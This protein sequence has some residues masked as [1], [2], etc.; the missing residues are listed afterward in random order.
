MIIFFTA[1]KKPQTQAPCSRISLSP[2]L[3]GQIVLGME[4]VRIIRN[5]K[6][7]GLIRSRL[8]GADAAT[9]PTL[10]F[11]D[12]HCECNVQWLEPLLARVH[13]DYRNVVSPII[14][15]IDHKNFQYLSTTSNLRGAFTWGLQFT[16]ETEPAD[17]RS[18]PIAPIIRSSSRSLVARPP[19]SRPAWLFVRSMR[20]T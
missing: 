6:R 12:S 14:D 9:S 10:T 17:S 2:A 19:G 15:V 18:S 3:Q 20:R 7:E 11:L 8:I 1:G 16:W 5:T 4:K 13:A